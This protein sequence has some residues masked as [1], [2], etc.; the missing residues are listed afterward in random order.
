MKN[1]YDMEKT[2]LEARIV[3]E[4]ERAGRKIQSLTDELESK[5]AEA[6][7]DKDMELEYLQEQLQSL[8][9]HQ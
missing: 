5:I 2:Q 1:V 6:T 8:E 9:Q 7:R 4:K 3:E